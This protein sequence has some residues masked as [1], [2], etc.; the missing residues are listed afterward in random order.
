LP[1]TISIIPMPVSQNEKIDGQLPVPSSP[2]LSSVPQATRNV[3]GKS[4]LLMILTLVGAGVVGGEGCRESVPVTPDQGLPRVERKDDVRSGLNGKEA[5][6]DIDRLT[7][8]MDSTDSKVEK[9]WARYLEDKKAAEA[10]SAVHV[11]RKADP[12]LRALKQLIDNGVIPDDPVSREK[13]LADLDASGRIIGNETLGKFINSSEKKV[14]EAGRGARKVGEGKAAKELTIE[15]GGTLVDPDL[16]GEYEAGLQETKQQE[17]PSD[18]KKSL[19][20]KKAAEAERG[21]H[22]AGEGKTTGLGKAAKSFPIET[23][24]SDMSGTGAI[25]P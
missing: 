8:R 6:T 9:L 22:K 14:A 15:P 19:E 11:E 1:S 23:P 17:K 16:A 2:S 24:G 21:T 12:R 13:A 4:R 3:S 7:E 18:K 10:E 5:K 20:A 25:I